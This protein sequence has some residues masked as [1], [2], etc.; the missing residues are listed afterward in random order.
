MKQY[1]IINAQQEKEGP[2]TLEDLKVVELTPETY[3]WTEG[4][5]DWQ[6]LKDLPEL[7]ALLSQSIP[8]TFR[9]KS[10]ESVEEKPQEEA[11]KEEP[12]KEKKK[13][14]PPMPDTNLALAIFSTICCCLPLGIVA[15]IY[16]N[17]VST[18]II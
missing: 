11:S 10:T 7:Y 6:P 12:L 1:Y 16:S 9:P 15:I 3:I 5:A 4:M 14:V 2:F 17:K 18:I 13:V 8:P